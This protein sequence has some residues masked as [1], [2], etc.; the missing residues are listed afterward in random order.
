MFSSFGKQLVLLLDAE[1]LL[2]VSPLPSSDLMRISHNWV[3]AS[4]FTSIWKLGVTV[5][6]F[7]Y[8]KKHKSREVASIVPFDQKRA[9]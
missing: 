4:Q 6:S 9:V 5:L 2:S 7:A 3:S 1:K 8:N